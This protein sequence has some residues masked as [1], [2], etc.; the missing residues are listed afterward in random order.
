[1]PAIIF[2]FRFIFARFGASAQL[3]LKEKI[4]KKNP[5]ELLEELPR[6]SDNFFEKNHEDE[7]RKKN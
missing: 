7:K 5:T 2:L 4:G 3:S 1:M 6:G